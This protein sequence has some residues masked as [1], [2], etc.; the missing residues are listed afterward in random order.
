MRL[1]RPVFLT[2][3]LAAALAVR[4]GVLLAVRDVHVG[5]EA[6]AGAEGAQ[7]NAIARHIAQGKGYT[8]A[9]GHP[10]AV[11]APG[12]PVFLA[13]LY[14]VAGEWPVMVYLT[15]C[16]LGAA[17][18]LLAYLLARE[19]LSEGWARLI[20][21]LAV[22]NLPHVYLATV[23]APDNLFIPLLLL[24]AWL[25]VRHLKRDSFPSLVAAGI[26]LGYAALTRPA[27]LLLLPVFL[28][29]ILWSQWRRRSWLLTPA[30]ALTVSFFS[31]I[32]PWT[33]RNYH[34]IGRPVLIANHAGD[35]D[36]A[37]AG[38]GRAAS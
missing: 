27:A 4:L 35:T 37:P 21:V 2:L 18:C 15:C 14:A 28:L 11:R 36:R 26:V 30:A 12:F 23:Y 5:P 22:V 16:L 19:L 31:V 32:F 24:S 20:G 13:A 17:S 8:D 9:T 33:A 25:V 7:H 29:A 6:V 3:L 38:Q 10:T 34:V 1:T